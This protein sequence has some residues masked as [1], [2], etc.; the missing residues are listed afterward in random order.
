[1]KKPGFESMRDVR[2]Q[3][4]NRALIRSVWDRAKRR[5]EYWRKRER[6]DK[7]GLATIQVLAVNDAWLSCL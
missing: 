3:I 4:K 5:C 7:D 6:K 1:M 2:K